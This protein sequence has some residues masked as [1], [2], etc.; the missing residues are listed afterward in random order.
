MAK[1]NQFL[2]NAILHQKYKMICINDTSNDYDFET[3]K[4]EINDALERVL[5][6]KSEF[7]K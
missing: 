6:K 4:K 5:P 2:I 3:V 1:E 7:E